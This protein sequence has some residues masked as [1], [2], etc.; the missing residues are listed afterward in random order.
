ME[1]GYTLADVLRLNIE[2]LA[3]LASGEGDVLLVSRSGSDGVEVRI[4]K[5]GSGVLS[6]HV[7]V[8]DGESIREVARVSGSAS[9][10][11]VSMSG[12][13]LHG[14]HVRFVLRA[15]ARAA[16][17]A[18]SGTFFTVNGVRVVPGSLVGLDDECLGRVVQRAIAWLAGRARLR[19]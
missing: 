4:E 11:T 17:A 19:R 15:V 5:R 8:V 16:C 7:S 14:A 10:A 12:E 1:N 2:F 9:R 18:V 3:E 13:R 6:G